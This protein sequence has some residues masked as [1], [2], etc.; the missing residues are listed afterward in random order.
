MSVKTEV[1]PGVVM[2]DCNKVVGRNL[3]GQP[4]HTV[5][6]FLYVY[7]PDWFTSGVSFLISPQGTSFPGGSWFGLNTTVYI[8]HCKFIVFR[9]NILYHSLELNS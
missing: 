2:T 4:R 3:E 9:I 7:V 6:M 1:C 8:Q 5:F